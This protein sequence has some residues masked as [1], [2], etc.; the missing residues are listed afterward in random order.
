ML[1]VRISKK[2]RHGGCAYV[3]AL[4]T[5]TKV[6][7]NS[8]LCDVVGVAVPASHITQ[9]KMGKK[10]DICSKAQTNLELRSV[11]QELAQSFEEM[12]HNSDFFTRSLRFLPV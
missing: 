2:Y 5:F 10:S 8:V 4:M 12:F 7:P 1:D 11:S 3:Y 6:Y 9:S